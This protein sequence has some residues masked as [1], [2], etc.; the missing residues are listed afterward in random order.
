[1]SKDEW[2]QE[3]EFFIRKFESCIAAQYVW[4]DSGVDPRRVRVTQSQGM[5]VLHVD[6]TG[7]AAAESGA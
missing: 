4:M 7:K 1:M 2:S 3:D 6:G 5:F